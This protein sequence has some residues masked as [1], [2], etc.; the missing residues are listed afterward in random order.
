MSL[1]YL[2]KVKINRNDIVYIFLMAASGFLMSFSGVFFDL[3]LIDALRDGF[4]IGPVIGIFILTPFIFTPFLG[5]HLFYPYYVL[6]YPNEIVLVKRGVVKYTKFFIAK[7][8]LEGIVYS[9]HF[10]KGIHLVEKSIYRYH[11]VPLYPSDRKMKEKE[12]MIC[13]T[14]EQCGIKKITTDIHQKWITDLSKSSK[15][16]KAKVSNFWIMK[17][18][19]SEYQYGNVTFDENMSQQEILKLINYEKDNFE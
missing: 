19:S 8:S 2:L 15:E 14:L 3:L 7:Y 18:I 4:A 5:I 1:E 16:M 11:L 6:V 10:G 17:D 13:N 9:Y 12:E